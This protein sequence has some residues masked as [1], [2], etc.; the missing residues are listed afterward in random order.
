MFAR[1]D[2]RESEQ[3][4]LGKDEGSQAER[5]GPRPAVWPKTERGEAYA[6][7]PFRESDLVFW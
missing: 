1:I 6:N 2:G 5:I 3:V 4:D 7:D